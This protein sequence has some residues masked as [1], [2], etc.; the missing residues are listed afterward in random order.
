MMAM[1]S[2][3]NCVIPRMLK[4]SKLDLHPGN[5]PSLHTVFISTPELLIVATETKILEGEAFHSKP[6]LNL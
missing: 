1:I 3:Y 6:L 4:C 5:N 2:C